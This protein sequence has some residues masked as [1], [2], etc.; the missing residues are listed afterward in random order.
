M[1]VPVDVSMRHSS[2]PASHA[3]VSIAVPSRSRLASCSVVDDPLEVGADLV[4]ARVGA[5]PVRVRV[6][7]EA[8]QVR[9]HVARD[10]GIGVVAPG[11]ADGCR[12]L[13]DD[14]I[15]AARA[16]QRHRHAESGEAGADDRD[17]DV[18]RVPS[19]P[20]GRSSDGR[21]AVVGRLA[22]VRGPLAERPEQPRR[23]GRGIRH[24]QFEAVLDAGLGL[25]ATVE[26][27]A[28]EVVAARAAAARRRSRGRRA[29]TGS[30][31]AGCCRSARAATPRPS[32]GA[33][34]GRCGPARAARRRPARGAGWAR[35]R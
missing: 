12:P 9:R 32:R 13:E 11:A 27:R 8:V 5:R 34:R 24:R 7:G 31:C 33:R 20:R 3:A 16:A 18:L 17:L 19:E 28:A 26:E 30:G 23:D 1:T 2:A 4:A 10:A 14:E 25:H 22:V 35:T 15:V 29:S 6:V 21:P